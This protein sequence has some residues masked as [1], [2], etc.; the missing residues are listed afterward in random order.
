MNK[1]CASW[2]IGFTSIAY[3]MVT[4]TL[5]A[6]IGAILSSFGGEFCQNKAESVV[7]LLNQTFKTPAFS[8][9]LNNLPNINQMIE[10]AGIHVPFNLDLNRLNISIPINSINFT[11]SDL[12]GDDTTQQLTRLPEY[13]K[14]L[15]NVEVALHSAA[16]S[17]AAVTLAGLLTYT[18][19][20]NHRLRKQMRSLAGLDEDTETAVPLMLRSQSA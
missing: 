9:S 10:V 5:G 2:S 16:I 17:A 13:A 11:L 8:I 18:Y 4:G 12:V 14:L 15:C 19:Q 20:H 7:Q 3:S 6:G 1:K